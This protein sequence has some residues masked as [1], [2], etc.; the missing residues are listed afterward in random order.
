MMAF[1]ALCGTEKQILLCIAPEGHVL[2]LTD[3]AAELL[4]LH[5]MSP[6]AEALSERAAQAVTAA[7]REGGWLDLDEEIEE[8]M[9]R[10]RSYPCPAGLLLAAEPY[11]V[12]DSMQKTE[13]I[14]SLRETNVLGSLMNIVRDGAE[15]AQS[16]EDRARWERLRRLTGRARRTHLH[17]EIIDGLHCLD[18][19]MFELDLA[20]L[21]RDIAETVNKMT[22]IPIDAPAGELKAVMSKEMFLF[23]LLNLLTNAVA[24][25]P[26][27]ITVGLRRAAGHLYLQVSDTAGELEARE[28]AEL[29]GGWQG[30]MA[31]CDKREIA[32]KGLGLPAVQR[33]LGKL[34]GS[35]LARAENGETHFI[36][37]LPD[38]LTEDPWETCR[39]DISS[40][41]EDLVE[42]E[43]TVL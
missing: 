39:M 5:P 30:S 37:V 43:L 40:G 34:G 28:I 25:R 2:W 12:G 16:E 24:C 9:Y 6:V 29:L 4:D 8:R 35:L 19:R 13:F 1:Q 23:V 11:E 17:S 15:H 32:Q 18:E 3:A 41:I 22:G 10:L 7:A 27:H 31:G 38:D 14:R 21:C 20:A 26:E 42:L 36:A 33:L